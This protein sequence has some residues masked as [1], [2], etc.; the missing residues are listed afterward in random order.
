MY[1]VSIPHRARSASDGLAYERVLPA[2]SSANLLFVSPN[3]ILPRSL[4]GLIPVNVVSAAGVTR[5]NCEVILLKSCWIGFFLWLSNLEAPETITPVT[6]K[7]RP[8]LYISIFPERAPRSNSPLAKICT[9]VPDGLT[10]V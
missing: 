8:L 9:P 3:K 4:S 1:L 7:N 6:V 5:P 10:S 2:Q